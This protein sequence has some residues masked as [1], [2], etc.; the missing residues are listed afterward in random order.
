M[1]ANQ[2]WLKQITKLG[3]LLMVGASMSA[4]A[5]LF[6]FGGT[7]W[8]EEV[9]LHDGS[10]IIVK[11]SQSYGGRHEIGQSSPIKEQEIT[12]TLPKSNK[13]FTFKSE[14]SE[15]IG[16]RNFNLLA[17]HILNGTPYIVAE[18]WLCLSYNKWGRPN[19]PYVFFKHD[20]K[21]W[22]LISLVEFPAEF[23]T[24]NLVVSAANYDFEKTIA[25][26][27]VISVERVKE[28]NAGPGILKTIRHA[29]YPEAAGTCGEMIYD[30]KGTWRGIDTFSKKPTYEACLQ[31]CEQKK[32]SPQY[33]PCETL[34]K[35]K[36]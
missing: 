28:L 27:S 22:Q 11:R 9:L 18:P 2:P 6:G 17:L 36:K 3:F 1:R 19:P 16:G 8:K 32:I 4:D 7:S 23:K 20:G 34:F 30:G 31:Y 10:K 24:I 15:D 26:Q 12:F 25:E 13:T 14:Y 35:G 5:G 21:E 33:C 29:P